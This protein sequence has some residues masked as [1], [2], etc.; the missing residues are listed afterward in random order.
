MALSLGFFS[1]A[2]SLPPADSFDS[3]TI[4]LSAPDF[5]RDGYGGLRLLVPESTTIPDEVR[6]PVY[7]TD[8]DEGKPMLPHRLVNLI[9]PPDADLDS[10][11]LEIVNTQVELVPDPYQ[12][13][14]AEPKVLGC[15]PESSGKNLKPSDRVLQDLM[16]LLPAN[17]LANPLPSLD[18]SRLF[19]RHSTPS[20]SPAVTLLPY[21][22][23]RKWKMAMLDYQP[24]SYDV[25]SGQLTVASQVT[26]KVTF[27]RDPALLDR[28]LLSDT[29]MDSMMPQAADNFAEALPWY[30]EALASLGGPLAPEAVNDYLVITT[31]AIYNNSILGTY[32]QFLREHGHTVSAFTTS[33][34]GGKTGQSLSRAIRDEL[35]VIFPSW[36]LVNV[37]LVGDP[38]TDGN[39]VPMA[40]MY[41]DRLT[42][43]NP[44]T[45]SPQWQVPTD[46]FY[47]NLTGNWD[48]NGNGYPGEAANTDLGYAGDFDAGGVSFAPT[49]HVGRIP[50]Y[51]N[52]YDT[53]NA[54]LQKLMDYQSAPGRPTW[55]NN[56]IL[57]HSFWGNEY[58]GA[59]LGHLANTN[60]LN[61]KGI[62]AYRIYSNFPT[63]ATGT[64]TYSQV[65]TFP[66]DAHIGDQV[67]KNYW[68]A[69]PA[70]LMVW[71]GHGNIAVTCTG[72]GTKTEDCWHE[73][74]FTS[75]QAAALDDTRPAFTY[76]NS[77]LN[78][79]PENSDNLGYSLLKNGAVATVS[80]SRVTWLDSQGETQ[81][82]L[83]STYTSAANKGY[84]Y[85]GRLMIGQTAGEALDWAAFQWPITPGTNAQNNFDFNL[86]GDPAMIF[87]VE[88]T[89]NVPAP[90][91]LTGHLTSINKVFY[92]ELDW[93]D[94]STKETYFRITLSPTD[95]TPDTIVNVDR[96]R[97]TT[98][99][100]VPTCSKS[101]YIT[102]NAGN[103]VN[104]SPDSNTLTLA[105]QPC[106]PSAP[107]SLTGY[108]GENHVKLVW[109]DVSGES[110]YHIK[111]RT[112]MGNL[113]TIPFEV[114]TVGTNVTT[115]TDTSSDCYKT[116]IYTIAAYNS[117]GESNP[118]PSLTINS[119][120][121]APP[122]PSNL[123]ATSAQTSIML[124]WT[125][126]SNDASNGEAGFE[127]WRI[128]PSGSWMVIAVVEPDTT[129]YLVDGL[130]CGD[131]TN[132]WYK[133]AAY[134]NG[135][136]SESNEI[137]PQPAGCT[138]PAAPSDLAVDDAGPYPDS[139]YLGWE[140][141]SN[142][143]WGFRIERLNAGNWELAASLD[144]NV[145]EAQ[146]HGLSCSG[147]FEFR[148][149]AY[150]EAGNSAE[151]HSQTSATTAAC[152]PYVPLN[153]QG[154]GGLDGITLTWEWIGLPPVSF[155]IQRASFIGRIFYWSKIA[156]PAGS[157]RSYLDTD[158]S[159]GHTYY[160]RIRS[161][162]A[163]G[164]LPSAYTP[165]M[166]V[167]NIV[168][169]PGAP[170][171]LS[172]Q[173]LS[174]TSI[175]LY[176]RPPLDGG[177]PAGYNIYHKTTGLGIWTLAGTTSADERTFT[178]TH[179]GCGNSY[180]YRVS[181]SN[182]GGMGPYSSVVTRRT[183][184][185]PPT[186][187]SDLSR[188]VATL[189]ELTLG[190]ADN[191]NNEDGFIL[192]RLDPLNGWADAAATATGINR[193]V[194]SGLNCG[195]IYIYRV[196]SFNASGESTPSPELQ[197]ATRLCAPVVRA[198]AGD[199]GVVRLTWTD[200]TTFPVTYLV[201]RQD[202]TGAWTALGSVEP[203]QSG[204]TDL[205]A[206][207]GATLHY[208]V[209]GTSPFADG[210]WSTPADVVT[211]CAPTTVITLNIT[212]S[213][214][215]SISLDWQA[216]AGGHSSF[217]LE[218]SGDGTLYWIDIAS[219]S[220]RTDSFVDS[221]LPAGQRFF[222]RL[223]AVNAGGSTLSQVVSAW[224][225]FEVMLP[226][227]LK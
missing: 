2:S 85:V 45:E 78:G 81:A 15:V 217:I 124:N 151:P 53:L 104:L 44:T 207:C 197:T 224:T 16:T 14:L 115:F 46:L 63:P 149:Y 129:G 130:L 7:S 153:F 89:A 10:L 146:I 66:H 57:A 193:V 21:A 31:D 117:G 82:N 75:N 1:S 39:G 43:P 103:G 138:V 33:R 219:L 206:P 107:T 86:Y 182:A 122:A 42:N 155:D 173:A 11:G 105:A 41:P 136:R 111:R 203:G 113:M 92:F 162:P 102:I 114:G 93:Q 137:H 121:C 77:C 143:E 90:T 205:N 125:D 5:D 71:S 141:N 69:H 188:V 112:L 51:D 195:T 36:G 202:P 72:F 100:P 163:I 47:A 160:Y 144:P 170:G 18:L 135:G 87:Y 101:F 214:A 70:G 61:P 148:V 99:I 226:A 215:H 171:A 79:R 4:N 165:S 56:A 32:I 17:W 3:I 9:L 29:A 164:T 157:A 22:Q 181:A 127:I 172:A 166:R 52:D 58:D 210:A 140:D 30:T 139:V 161:V 189:T 198:H 211:T 150:N 95:A 184:E 212:S 174:S 38:A 116:Y 154:S 204:F 190:W 180:D 74:L 123:T 110:G 60:F 178:D 27:H 221:G 65:S 131:T 88:P 50:V 26:V 167:Q 62:S 20:A 223:R 196:L 96:N 179:L 94:N 185:C 220:P 186:A 159:C 67:L 55:R 200:L 158:V 147:G 225:K 192:Q 37:L 156:S 216:T 213:S 76:Q 19:V 128:L 120:K 177:L 118:S 28:T 126:N 106:P 98:R 24:F 59:V 168:C 201:E 8:V 199:Q 109:N 132:I 48:L 218:R 119:Q 176:W 91:G 191:S 35:K 194:D 73:Y 152:D 183:F 34:Y 108:I 169:A 6:L 68:S 187:P 83:P 23:I 145:T 134:N 133:V 84:Q 142:N 25:P 208:R 80:A 12:I 49:L 13:P 227:V 64:C 209:S 40:M 97:I 54:I 175:H 222:Y